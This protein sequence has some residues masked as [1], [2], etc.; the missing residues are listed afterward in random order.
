MFRQTDEL[1]LLVSPSLGALDGIVKVNFGAVASP[2]MELPKA[3]YACMPPMAADE[4]EHTGG[5]NRKAQITRKP[6]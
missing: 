3:C 1:L 5:A 2:V 6:A 4:C